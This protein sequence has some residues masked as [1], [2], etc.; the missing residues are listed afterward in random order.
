MKHLDNLIHNASK[1]IGEGFYNYA[2]VKNPGVSGNASIAI[3]LLYHYLH[4]EDEKFGIQSIKMIQ[5]SVEGMSEL[6]DNSIG[7]FAGIAW[8]VQH[9]INIG[10]LENNFKDNF[11]LIDALLDKSIQ[12]DAINRDYDLFYGLVGRGTYFLERF[13]QTN[14]K[15]ILSKINKVVQAL[16]QIAERSKLGISW[17]YLRDKEL[18]SVYSLGLAHGISS[19]ILFLSKLL[20]LE[21]GIPNTKELVQGSIEWLLNRKNSNKYYSFESES[22]TDSRNI[23]LPRLAWCNGDLGISLSLLS[24]SEA[25][26]SSLLRKEAIDVATKTIHRDLANSGV[27]MQGEFI[28]PNFCHGISGVAHIYG[29]LFKATGNGIFHDRYEYWLMELI[30]ARRE[31]CG[32]AGYVSDVWLGFDWNKNMAIKK[33]DSNPSLLEGTSGV[34]L[35]LLSALHEKYK[36][37]KLFLTDF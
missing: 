4:T 15:H 29:R 6:K 17:K 26:S 3:Y 1:D 23:E 12:V 27:Y 21:L 24:A 10:I 35:V 25:L 11:R 14:S 9:F 28:D 19:V 5:Q 20:K 33:W 37:D 34:G 32:I 8:T 13:E 2:P 18:G 31:S 16:N 36:W 7:G 22:N 30:K